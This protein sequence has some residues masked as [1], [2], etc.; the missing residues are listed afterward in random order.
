MLG[1]SFIGHA[2]FVFVQVATLFILVLAANTA[3]NGFPILAS[4]AAQDALMPAK[5]RKRGHRLVYSNGILVLAAG[6]ASSW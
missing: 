5:L 1:G 2:L 3:F 4:F 6:A